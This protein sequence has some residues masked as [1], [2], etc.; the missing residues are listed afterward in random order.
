MTNTNEGS[1]TVGNR[2]NGKIGVFDKM[3]KL[4]RTFDVPSTPVTAG[5]NDG[6]GAAVAI[7]FSPDRDQRLM[8]VI[9]QNN[10][11][12]E[13]MDRGSG[14]V[15]GNFGRPGPYPGEFNH[16]HCIAIDSHGSI[17]VNE[18]RGRLTEKFKLVE[19]WADLIGS[20]SLTTP[21]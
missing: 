11:R 14:K 5:V 13:I 10:S 18:K 8:F 19:G 16:A 7:A 6:G 15:L 1:V 20:I 4:Q 21:L 17:Y 12:I 9:N 3:G 2:R